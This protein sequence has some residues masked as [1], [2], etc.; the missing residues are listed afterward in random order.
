MDSKWTVR[1]VFFERVVLLEVHQLVADAAEGGD[2]R[3]CASFFHYGGEGAEAVVRLDMELE[4]FFAHT[5]IV[6]RP[7]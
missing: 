2:F 3:R 7:G 5:Y 1:H 6:R 4:G